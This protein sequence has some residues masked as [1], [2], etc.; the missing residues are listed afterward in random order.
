MM[1]S[2]KPVIGI[3]MGSESDLIVM[4]SAAETLDKFGI[5]YEL[6]ITSAHRSPQQTM[7]YAKRAEPRGIKVIIAGAGGAAHLPGVVAAWCTIPV[8]GVPVRTR[9]FKGVDSFISMVE[10]PKG[11]PVATVGIDN[12]ANAALLATAILG[13]NNQGIRNK[14][15]KYR[16]ELAHKVTN[17][18][19]KNKI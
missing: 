15:K 9:T 16:Q 3:L 4:Q 5:A 7:S 1:R 2:K 17:S 12:A 14:L 8:I 18:N 11:V 6:V 13:V 19:N 10:M